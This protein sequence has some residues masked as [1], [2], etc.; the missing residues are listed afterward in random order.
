MPLP[1]ALFEKVLP[2]LRLSGVPVRMMIMATFGA[3]IIS[4]VGFKMLFQNLSEKRLLLI[5]P[6]LI[7]LFFEYMPGALPKTQINTPRYVNFLKN[8][9]GDKGVIDMTP[10]PSIALYFQT[11]HEKPTTFGYI[12]RIPESIHIKDKEL[13]KRINQVFQLPK[14]VSAED[15]SLMNSIRDE[16]F[17]L[18][19]RDYKVR[20]LIT[21]ANMN[22]LSEYHTIKLLYHDSKVNIY[23][24]GTKD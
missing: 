4:A 13:T 5:V 3:S 23:D 8:L 17:M 6:L 24:L 21:S 7:L 18:L 1:Y 11:I 22:M 14:Y 19:R 20:Y 12:A 16:L 9:P 15:Q 2:P 10:E